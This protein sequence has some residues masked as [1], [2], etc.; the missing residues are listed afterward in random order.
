MLGIIF[1]PLEKNLRPVRDK[2]P[3]SP[4]PR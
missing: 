3:N 4:T 1:G 2:V